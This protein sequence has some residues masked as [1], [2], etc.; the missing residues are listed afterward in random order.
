MDISSLGFRTDLALAESAGA[1]IEHR[2]DHVVVRTPGNPTYRWGNFILIGESAPIKKADHWLG[3]FDREFPE[4][5]HRALG[6]DG[7]RGSLDDLA[8]LKAAG[9][10]LISR[11]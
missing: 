2:D 11:P 10:I 4:A 6:R 1:L 3:V 5:E 8:P 7:T 9:M